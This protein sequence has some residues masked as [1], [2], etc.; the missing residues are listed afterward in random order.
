VECYTSGLVCQQGMADPKDPNV[1]STSKIM[2]S[3]GH[4]L[5]A[6]L[7]DSD[8]AVLDFEKVSM[9]NL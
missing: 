1:I 5:R 7:F 2:S 4:R 8:L 3:F 9:G 6:L